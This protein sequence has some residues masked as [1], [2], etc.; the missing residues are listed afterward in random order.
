MIRVMIV[1][2]QQLLCEGLKTIL[3]MEPDLEV[4]GMARHGHEALSLADRL[5]PDVVL[6]DI[7]MPRMD[8]VECTRRLLERH[9]GIHVLILTTYDDDEYVFEALK[10]GAS[11]YLL[12]DLP[13]SD[14]IKA[15][16]SVME[17]DTLISPSVASKV[18]SEFARMARDRR[19]S[20]TSSPGDV[21]LTARELE[22][23]RLVATGASNREIAETLFITE[24]TVKNHLSNILAKLGARDRTQAAVYAWKHGLVDD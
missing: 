22:V 10:A 20:Q 23:L 17:G 4:V 12:K 14:L 2:D 21:G 9:P 18:V 11:G 19:S 13:A 8:G 5:A 6:M 7:R 16:R 1:D 3:D 15:V 24:G